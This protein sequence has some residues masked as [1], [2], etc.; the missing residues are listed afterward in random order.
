MSI[1]VSCDLRNVYTGGSR[2]GTQAGLSGLVVNCFVT[3]FWLYKN[4]DRRIQVEATSYL[5][6]MLIC[7]AGKAHAVQRAVQVLVF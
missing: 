1:L 3:A 7:A 5:S 2:S 6:V 4:G